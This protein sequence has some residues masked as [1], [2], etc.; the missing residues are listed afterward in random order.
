MI[1]VERALRFDELDQPGGVALDQ[2]LLDARQIGGA[3]RLAGV[4]AHLHQAFERG[5]RDADQRRGEL[6]QVG[7][8]RRTPSAAAP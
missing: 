8:V 4:I 5:D 1:V 6:R 7:I 2:V 3:E